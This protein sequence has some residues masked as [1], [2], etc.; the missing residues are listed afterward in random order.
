M[1]WTEVSR[2][3]SFGN[4]R[5]EGPRSGGFVFDVQV[6]T[7]S[8][9]AGPATSFILWLPFPLANWRLIR[10][11]II[12]SGGDQNKSSIPVI[13][14]LL[15]IFSR[16]PAFTCILVHANTLLWISLAHLVLAESRFN[17]V[18]GNG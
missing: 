18:K 13:M 7:L 12:H 6:S 10:K 15:S 4:S 3:G 2:W 17:A 8:V 9:V 1:P 16:D 5:E 14:L 11:L